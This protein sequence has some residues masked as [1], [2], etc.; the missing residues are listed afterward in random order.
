MSRLICV[1]FQIWLRPYCNKYD[2]TSQVFRYL[3]A[4]R[5]IYLNAKE[6]QLFLNFLSKNTGSDTEIAKYRY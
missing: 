5:R 2:V 4:D 1:Q 6:T 3:V